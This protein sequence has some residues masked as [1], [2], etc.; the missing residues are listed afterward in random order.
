VRARRLLASAVLAAVLVGLAVGVAGASPH[1]GLDRSFGK[2]GV[3]KLQPPFPGNYFPR[4]WINGFAAAPDGSAYVLGEE[5]ECGSAACNHHFLTRYGRDGGRDESYGEGGALVLSSVPEPAVAADAAGR[6]L[7][8]T[9]EGPTIT[10]RRLTL[11]GEPDQGFGEAGAA[12]YD[13]GCGAASAHLF[14]APAG[15]ILIEAST[16]LSRHGREA[17]ATRIVLFR[18][19]PDGRPDRSFGKAGAIRFTIDKPGPPHSV[20]VSPRGAIFFAGVT[21]GG[22]REIYLDRVAPSGRVDRSFDRVAAH[23][24]RR[25][26][27]LGEF[28]ELAALAPRGDGGLDV[29]GTSGSGT[30]FDLRLPFIVEAAVAGADGAVVVVGYRPYASYRAFL[31]RR[32]GSFDHAFQA[33]KGVAIP[34]IGSPLRLAK[35]AGGRVLVTDQGRRF[36]REGC[37][38]E[39]AMARLLE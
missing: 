19:L 12:H 31:I 7:L 29:L 15:R 26:N 11:D 32:D 28:P 25:L 4:A 20:V 14:R 27:T 35:Q 3:V 24:V 9:V 22:P 36:C 21:S 33:A 10:V 39:P 38:P 8:A 34:I 5:V 30:G 18:A 37:G 2:G 23:A 16:V 13:C 1:A 6:A 17:A